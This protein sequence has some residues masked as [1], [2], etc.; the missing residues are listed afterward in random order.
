MKQIEN[1][2]RNTVISEGTLKTESIIE[3]IARWNGNNAQDKKTSKLI[4][5]FYDAI[6]DA[7]VPGDFV[8]DEIFER[9]NNIAPDDC[10]FGAHE[11]DGALFGF[12]DLE[13]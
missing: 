9:L 7:D 13:V 3:N 12:W 5:D 8:L 2:Y 1:T 6:C 11:G 10:Y 4:C